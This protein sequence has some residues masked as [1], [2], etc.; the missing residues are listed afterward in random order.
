MPIPTLLYLF[1]SELNNSGDVVSQC[2]VT[3][4]EPNSNALFV[5]NSLLFNIK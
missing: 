5:N 1:T 3:I 4:S 2:T